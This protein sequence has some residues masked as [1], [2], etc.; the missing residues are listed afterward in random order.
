VFSYFIVTRYKSESPFLL[1][2]YFLLSFLVKVLV[3]IVIYI[4]KRINM[5]EACYCGS[6]RM[7]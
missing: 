2:G 4:T 7:A 6:T 1:A 3:T 5:L